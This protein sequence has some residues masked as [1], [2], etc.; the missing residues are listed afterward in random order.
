MFGLFCAEYENRTRAYCLGSN[1]SAT[2]LI[3]LIIMIPHNNTMLGVRLT[4][5]RMLVVPSFD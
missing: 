3:P 2:K 4:Y 1:R 5:T